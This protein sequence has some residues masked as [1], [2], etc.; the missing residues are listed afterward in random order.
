MYL[1]ETLNLANIMAPPDE[2]HRSTRRI[3]VQYTSQSDKYW[4]GIWT[5]M[6]TEWYSLVLENNWWSHSRA[7]HITVNYSQMCAFK[8]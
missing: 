2:Y 8:A 3:H 1:Q 7:W 4:C 6:R 5:D